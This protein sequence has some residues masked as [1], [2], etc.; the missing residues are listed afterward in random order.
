MRLYMLYDLA[1][2]TKYVWVDFFKTIMFII[3]CQR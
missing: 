1:V 2:Y 3:H